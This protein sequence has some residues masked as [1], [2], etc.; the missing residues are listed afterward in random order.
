MGMQGCLTPHCNSINCDGAST[1]RRS[2]VRLNDDQ[3]RTATVG[4]RGPLRGAPSKVFPRPCTTCA[5][6]QV[7]A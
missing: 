6:L 4:S 2:A 3:P 1:S 5:S 7:A